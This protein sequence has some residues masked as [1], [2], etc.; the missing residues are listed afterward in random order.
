MTNE[1]HSPT[2]VPTD[3]YLSDPQTD[4][5]VD[6]KS[7]FISSREL[8]L[9]SSEEDSELD[10]EFNEPPPSRLKRFGLALFAV[11]LF[12]IAIQM[13]SAVLES[14][15]KPKVVYASRCA[16]RERSCHAVV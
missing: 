6:E 7:S 8:S 10:P 2:D 5:D 13:R 14:K 9:T 3:E 1:T 16:S 12:W 11:L 15:K 4:D